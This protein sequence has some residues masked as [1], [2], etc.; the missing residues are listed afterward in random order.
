MQ[1]MA[2]VVKL[3]RDT[4]AAYLTDN[5]LSLSASARWTHAPTQNVVVVADEYEA[6]LAG[7]ASRTIDSDEALPLQTSVSKS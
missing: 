5:A 6:I 7:T 1:P 4:D 2:S 3:E